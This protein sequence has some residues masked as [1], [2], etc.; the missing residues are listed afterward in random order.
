MSQ[1][2]KVSSR[3]NSRSLSGR[4]PLGEVSSNIPTPRVLISLGIEGQM[5]MVYAKTKE[6][7]LTL[8]NTRDSL[9]KE[10]EEIRSR[11]VLMIDKRNN[12]SRANQEIEKDVKKMKEDSE[13]LLKIRNDLKKYVN[14]LRNEIREVGSEWETQKRSM[15]HEINQLQ[16]IRKHINEE[17]S[18]E[19]VAF[20]YARNYLRKQLE[21]LQ[22]E[23]IVSSQEIQKYEAMIQTMK[24]RESDCRAVIIDETNKF[25][26]FI[27]SHHLT[28]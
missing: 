6:K 22:K 4:S 12:L 15:T 1:E 24:K 10:N 26:E 14:D 28:S 3:N 19:K 5:Q 7:V 16:T 23:I 2:R 21:T 25:K 9:N 18:K 20:D 11:I 8:T 17:K 13:N 27:E